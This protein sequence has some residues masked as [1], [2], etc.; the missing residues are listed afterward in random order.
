MQARGGRDQTI[1]SA[2]G[3]PWCLRLRVYGPAERQGHQ[4]G[5]HTPFAHGISPPV[6]STTGLNKNINIA[7]PRSSGVALAT[8]SPTATSLAAPGL[9]GAPPGGGRVPCRWVVRARTG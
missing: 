8:F 5:N 1:Q 9:K 3:N 2:R 4:H 6:Q 7:L